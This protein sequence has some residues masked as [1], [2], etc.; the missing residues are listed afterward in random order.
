MKWYI[1]QPILCIKSSPNKE[2]VKGQEFEI[3]GLALS[4]CNCGVVVIDVGIPNKYRTSM[5]ICGCCGKYFVG[6]DIGFVEK[7]FAP[8]DVDVSEL[9]DILKEPIKELTT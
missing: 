8:L 5:F 1:G 6:K 2:I 9:T 4:A 3:K 7:R